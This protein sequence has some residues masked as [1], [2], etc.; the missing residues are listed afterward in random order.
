[1]QIHTDYEY[2]ETELMLRWTLMPNLE[3]VLILMPKHVPDQSDMELGQRFRVSMT[4]LWLIEVTW[5]TRTKIMWVTSIGR[6]EGYVV[7]ETFM[8]RFK[9]AH[10]IA[11]SPGGEGWHRQ[12]AWS[13]ALA[14]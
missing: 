11:S 2:G 14:Q 13:L 10:S 6:L 9:A 5:G 12:Q 3:Q 7:D 1:M 8:A 4:L